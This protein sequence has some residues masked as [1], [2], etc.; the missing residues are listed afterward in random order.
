MTTTVKVKARAHGA[1]VS[2]RRVGSAVEGLEETLL[3]PF[4]EREFLVTKLEV[5]EVKE[6]EAP[7]QT[8]DTFF[9]E[10]EAKKFET[11]EGDPELRK[12]FSASKKSK[13]S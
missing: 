5:L 2:L 10:E 1:L 13:D 9:N 11:L 7:V 6:L 4:E 3:D 12:S 8:L